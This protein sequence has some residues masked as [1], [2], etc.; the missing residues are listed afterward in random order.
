MTKTFTQAEV[1]ALLAKLQATLESRTESHRKESRNAIDREYRT[2]RFA[3]YEESIM[4]VKE[5]ERVRDSLSH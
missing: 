4:A 2:S 5:V 1:D 3:Q